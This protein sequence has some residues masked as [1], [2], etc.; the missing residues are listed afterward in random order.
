[1]TI[2]KEG[3]DEGGVVSAA[4]TMEKKKHIQD[5]LTKYRIRPHSLLERSSVGTPGRFFCA[6]T[7]RQDPA[8]LSEQSEPIR[9]FTRGKNLI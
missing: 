2:T 5:E 1:M 3:R 6:T 8:E 4:S 7:Q 9:R